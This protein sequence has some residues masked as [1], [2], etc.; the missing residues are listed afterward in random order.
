[1]DRGTWWAAVYG[2]A[3]SWTR[4]SAF[5]F[6]FHFHALEKEMATRSSVLA[7]RI[8]GMAE[9]GGL[10]S[11]VSHRVGHDWGDLAAGAAAAAAAAE[12]NWVPKNWCFWT[13]VLEKLTHWKRLWCWE[14]SGARGERDDREWD[15]WMASLTRWTWVWVNSGRQWWTGRPGVLWF[16]GSPRVRHDWVTEL[17]WTDTC[18]NAI[19]SNHPTLAF[20][21][22][23]QKSVLYICVSFA[24]LHIGSLLPS[25]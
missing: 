20:S 23:V 3:W 18:F 16:M 17:N 22:R 25:F 15:G 24:V 19:L 21:H 8:P 1:M 9:P 13:V 12:E 7:W 11:M 10:P 5:T 2:V 4:L 14:G 6:T